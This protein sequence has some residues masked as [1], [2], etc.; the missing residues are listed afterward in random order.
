MSEV[1]TFSVLFTNQKTKKKKKWQD[2]TIA[3][4]HFNG[5]SK[6]SLSKEGKLMEVFEISEL[7]QPRLSISDR[8]NCFINVVDFIRCE[9]ESPA[10]LIQ[11]EH[12]VDT[13]M[14]ELPQ[15]K[16]HQVHV[17]QDSKSS[18]R[19]F[20]IHKLSNCRSAPYPYIQMS[21]EL[22]DRASH[23]RASKPPK[24]SSERSPS[25]FQYFIMARH[26]LCNRMFKSQRLL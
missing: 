10:H 16:G 22:I 17:D 12:E 20:P 8:F 15:P 21:S 26:Q 5:F 23:L 7:F 4:R 3:I 14:A 19:F 25:A 11:V 13:A 24:V 18:S 9:F 6:A 2:G 1:K